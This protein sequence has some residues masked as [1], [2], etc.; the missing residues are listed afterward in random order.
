[1]NT[2]TASPKKKPLPKIICSSE[3]QFAK[4]REQ[5]EML[6]EIIQGQIKTIEV[7]GMHSSLICNFSGSAYMPNHQPLYLPN[8]V[9]RITPSGSDEKKETLF[10]CKD[11]I[12]RLQDEYKELSEFTIE[13]VEMN[14]SPI[15]PQQ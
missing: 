7:N 2:S 3:E 5:F 11:Y 8:N 6:P 10:V 12:F 4:A 13:F 14:P 9:T 1:M 15:S